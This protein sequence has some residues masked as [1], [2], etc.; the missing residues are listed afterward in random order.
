MYR[1]WQ[2]TNFFHKTMTHRCEE[3]LKVFILAYFYFLPNSSVQ[4]T[5][6][7]IETKAASFSQSRRNSPECQF[8][9]FLQETFYSQRMLLFLNKSRG[10]M[11]T[12]NLALNTRIWCPRFVYI[13]K[14]KW[15]GFNAF[16]YATKVVKKNWQLNRGFYFF[17]TQKYQLRQHKHNE[18]LLANDMQPKLLSA[19]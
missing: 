8:K 11:K 15:G 14:N 9:L 2:T 13:E 4:M 19:C 18:F 3:I 5:F 16:F 17:L 12:F 6:F 10:D 1:S 7:L